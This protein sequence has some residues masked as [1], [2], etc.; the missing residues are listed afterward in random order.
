VVDAGQRS[1]AS[2]AEAG[3]NPAAGPWPQSRAIQLGKRLRD[4]LVA[5]ELRFSFVPSDEVADLRYFAA[6][7]LRDS[8]LSAFAPEPFRYVPWAQ[9]LAGTP[10]DLVVTT[11]HGGDHPQLLRDIR[12]RLAPEAVLLLWLWDNHWAYFQN[13]RAV[14][15]ADLVFFSHGDPEY[16][17]YLAT[18]AAV[19]CGHVAACCAQWAR[20]QAAQLSDRVQARR[21]HKALI[22]YVNYRHSWAER[23]RLLQAYASGLQNAEVLLMERDDRSRYF[24]QAPLQRFSEWAGYKATVIVP[25]RRDVST[26]VF[27][28]LLAGM[29]P[30]VPR[31]LTDFDKVIPL[32]EQE[33]LGIVRTESLELE[34]AQAAVDDALERFDAMGTQG[35][36]ARF[37]YALENHLLVNRVTEILFKVWQLGTGEI[38]IVVHSGENGPSLFTQ[39]LLK[40]DH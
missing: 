27:D 33:R 3:S 6:T 7:E 35:A 38:E 31:V 12:D 17:G 15:L 23:T 26:R 4:I 16:T 21:Q 32:Q 36:M 8:D 2:D 10:V 30:I 1:S 11:I 13:L 22:N 24:G 14:L 29:I 5:G 9:V 37:Q 39:R 25:V 34:P 20:C 40:V 18:P 19:L 28:A